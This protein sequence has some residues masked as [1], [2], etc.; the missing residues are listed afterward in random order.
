MLARAL[1]AL[2]ILAT[3][4]NILW[5]QN[6][7]DI[8]EGDHVAVRLTGDLA[9]KYSQQTGQL[10]NRQAP[11]GLEISTTATIAQKLDDGRIRLEHTSHVTRQG[12]QTRLVT[13]TAIVPSEK[14]KA[15]TTP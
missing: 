14:V 12:N 2:A 10:N 11:P 6:N 4:D 5:A 9:R 1:I 7:A 15:D 3:N 13:I 8:K